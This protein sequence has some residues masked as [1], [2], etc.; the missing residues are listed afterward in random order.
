M[1]SKARN[2]NVLFCGLMAES[3]FF[4]YLYGILYIIIAH[5]LMAVRY[6]LGDNP[7]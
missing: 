3:E 5:N 4:Q 2:Y 1:T 6:F 7:Q